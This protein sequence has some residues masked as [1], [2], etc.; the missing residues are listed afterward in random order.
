[1]NVLQLLTTAPANELI[2]VHNRLYENYP[3]DYDHYVNEFLPL[4]KAKVLIRNNAVIMLDHFVS[5]YDDPCDNTDTILVQ[6][7][8][9]NDDELYCISLVPWGE[10][11]ASEFKCNVEYELSL[12]EQAARV[13]YEFTFTGFEEDMQVIKDSL[14]DAMEDIRRIALRLVEEGSIPDDLKVHRVENTLDFLFTDETD[15]QRKEILE[16]WNRK[17]ANYKTLKLYINGVLQENKP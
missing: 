13:F 12:A 8:E 3:I 6:M 1:M 11:L 4:I 10:V 9:E 16:E 17:D 5:I 2:E 15:L 7:K 14:D